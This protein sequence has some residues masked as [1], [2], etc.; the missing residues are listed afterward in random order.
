[1]MLLLNILRQMRDWD[2]PSRLGFLIALI[3]MLPA[4]ALLAVGPPSLRL[5]SGIGLAGLIIVAQLIVMWANRG[6]V[7]PYTLDQRCFRAGD[8]E[9]ARDLLRGLLESGTRV[10]PDVLVLLGNT[11]RH[12]GDLDSSESVLRQAVDAQPDYHFSSYGFGRTLLAKGD[13]AA[14]ADYIDRALA[15]GAPPVVRFDLAHCYYRS[16]DA[17]L[18]RDLLQQIASHSDEPH[19]QLMAAL[20]LT[21]D[22]QRSPDPAL[23]EAGLPFWQAEVQRFETTPYGQAVAADVRRLQAWLE[24]N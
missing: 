17:R 9:Q 14:A 20:M 1:M 19:H 4:L 18:D 7:A 23:I 5:P 2:R 21:T 8:F 16:Q 22:A 12:L 6:M 15:Q 3:L 24:G 13:Y 10:H 11:Y